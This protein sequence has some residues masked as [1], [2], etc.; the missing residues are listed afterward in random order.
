MIFQSSKVPNTTSA[1][2]RPSAPL[3]SNNIAGCSNSLPTRPMD[4][5]ESG[6]DEIDG[7]VN[8][9]FQAILDQG[10]H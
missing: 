2:T 7:G 6:I 5:T 8:H 10:I 1:P 3:A 4:K 9:Q